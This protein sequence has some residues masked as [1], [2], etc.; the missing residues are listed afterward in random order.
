MGQLAPRL[1]EERQNHILDRFPFGGRAACQ[2]RQVCIGRWQR[3][4]SPP[5]AHEQQQVSPVLKSAEMVRVTKVIG[6]I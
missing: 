6:D 5:H 4:S 3:T 2:A 1:G